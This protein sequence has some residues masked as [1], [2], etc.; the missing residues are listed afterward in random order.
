M[1][2]NSTVFWPLQ[3]LYTNFTNKDLSSRSATRTMVL[4]ILARLNDKQNH[5]SGGSRTRIRRHSALLPYML[6][7][8]IG[9]PATF[10]I[11]AIS[12]A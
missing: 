10:P 11:K 3:E 4:S 8:L 7:P 9:F 6:P 12:Y 1:I 2:G 5:G